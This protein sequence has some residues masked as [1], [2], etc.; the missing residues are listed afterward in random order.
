M[1]LEGQEEIPEATFDAWLLKWLTAV[2]NCGSAV[3]RNYTVLQGQHDLG[4]YCNRFQDYNYRSSPPRHSFVLRLIRWTDLQ[5]AGMHISWQKIQD[6]ALSAVLAGITVV[7]LSPNW[8]EVPYI[9]R[10]T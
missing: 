5:E 8:T 6:I 4:T 10:K 1:L 7:N 9:T 3:R 2:V